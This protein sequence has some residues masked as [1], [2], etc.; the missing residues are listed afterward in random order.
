MQSDNKALVLGVV[1]RSSNS[2]EENDTNLSNIL[3]GRTYYKCMYVKSKKI[4]KDRIIGPLKDSSGQSSSGTLY[5]TETLNNFFADI[6]QM[7]TPNVKPIFTGSDRE[8]LSNLTFTPEIV[9]KHLS[10]LKPIDG[11]GSNILNK[12]KDYISVSLSILFSECK[13]PKNWKTANMTPVFRQ[14]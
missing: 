6:L 10:K 7:K 9:H 3:K 13:V 4:V 2:C 5:M 8:K 12:F 14:L 1:C 11:Y